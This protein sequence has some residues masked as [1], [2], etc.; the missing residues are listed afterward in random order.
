[1]KLLKYWIQRADYSSR[2]GEPVNATDAVRVFTSHDWKEE[3]ALMVRLEAADSDYCP[4]GI[5]FVDP[6]GPVLHICPGA[7][8][9][10]MVH[11]SGRAGTRKMLGFIPW[12]TD[13]PHHTGE[14]VD[15]ATVIN[16]IQ[17]FFAGQHDSVL[18]TFRGTLDLACALML[19]LPVHGPRRH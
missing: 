10:A 5:G 2:D 12:T 17:L 14:S 13:P 4:P 11:V 16:L 8:G 18:E 19:E 7:D 3:L 6:D 9:T 1:M 15:T